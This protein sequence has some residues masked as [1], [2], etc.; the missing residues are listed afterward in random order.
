VTKLTARGVKAML[1]RAGVDY[2]AL[3]ITDDPAVWVDVE[4]GVGTTSV[5]VR[6]PKP[7]RHQVGAV[8]YEKGLACAPYSDYDMWSRKTR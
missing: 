3:T 1:T 2:S 8:L 7:Q 4:T 6:G 5:V